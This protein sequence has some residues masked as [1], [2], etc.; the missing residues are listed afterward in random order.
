M[1]GYV[2]QWV[3]LTIKELTM[4]EIVDSPEETELF[5]NIEDVDTWTKK[6]CKET[7]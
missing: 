3:K 2:L 7:N 5:G 6:S 1:Y 4:L